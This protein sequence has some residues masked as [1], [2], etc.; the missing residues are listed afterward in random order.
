MWNVEI[1]HLKW[2]SDNKIFNYACT[3]G[4][5]LI[6]WAT[7]QTED[8]FLMSTA[9]LHLCEHRR[10]APAIRSSEVLYE[11]LKDFNSTCQRNPFDPELVGSDFPRSPNWT[12]MNFGV[13]A[14][15]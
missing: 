1:G 15:H 14:V 4:E 2:S 9:A 13:Q 10:N 11:I 7:Y 3:E 12:G 6:C 5:T 8:F